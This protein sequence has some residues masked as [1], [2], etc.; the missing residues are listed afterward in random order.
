MT[1]A[2]TDRPSLPSGWYYPTEG[3]AE[4]LHAELQRELPPG[5]LL[6]GRAVETFAYRRDQ[7]D[8]LFRHRD[9]PERFTVIHLS[10]IRKREINAQHPSVC[11]DGAFEKFF[12]EEE[13]F[14]G[15]RQKS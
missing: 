2:P 5:H 14:Y 10:W 6:F 7:D 13:G 1:N 11:F 12:V 4:R 9:N 15:E 3:E 8:V